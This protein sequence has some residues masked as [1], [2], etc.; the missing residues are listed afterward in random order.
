MEVYCVCLYVCFLVLF[1]GI[2]VCMGMLLFVCECVM[3]SEIQ[4][5]V[6]CG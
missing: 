2:S 6:R 4:G 3:S 1:A 5:S